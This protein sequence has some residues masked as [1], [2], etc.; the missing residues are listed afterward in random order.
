M[1][2]DL[3]RPFAATNP[4]NRTILF[5]GLIFTFLSYALRGFQPPWSYSFFNYTVN[6]T[7][8]Y[9]P[10][11]LWGTVLKLLNGNQLPSEFQITMLQYVLEFL[12]LAYVC[13]VIYKAVYVHGNLFSALVL[14]LFSISTYN[15]F[16]L[17]MVGFLDHIVYLFPLIY[18]EVCLRKNL[19][20]C[21]VVGGILSALTPLFLE[22]G[23]F[24]ICPII[25]SVTMIHLIRCKPDAWKKYLPYV[26]LAYI[27]TLLIIIGTRLIPIDPESVDLFLKE[28][29]NYSYCDDNF[30]TLAQLFKTT[31]LSNTTPHTWVYIPWEIV[32]YAA[33]IVGMVTFFLICIR[34]KKQVVIG[35]FSFSLLSAV[36]S[37]LTIYFGADYHRYYFAVVESILIITIY[38]LLVTKEQYLSAKY[39]IAIAAVAL[40]VFIPVLNYRLWNW[41][42]IY[43]DFWFEDLLNTVGLIG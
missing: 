12:F 18:I 27:P 40:V 36:A 9:I 13:Y 38:V 21:F 6:W 19:N 24:T 25:V 3:E 39:G 10:R 2:L 16:Y 20:T 34:A 37:Y 22:T 29:S 1:R 23:A 43:R 42:Q 30:R 4:R 32:V 28:A 5:C 11:G 35:Y 14:F 7:H 15:M 33:G 8:G 26:V 31:N 17:R 41:N